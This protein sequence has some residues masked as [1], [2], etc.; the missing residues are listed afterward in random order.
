MGGRNIVKKR[1]YSTTISVVEVQM[2]G[3][4]YIEEVGIDF[5][6]QEVK[7]FIVNVKNVEAAGF[8]D[9]PAEA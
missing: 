6:N 9:V 4:H 8:D 3:R 5:T 7:K 1:D 2:L